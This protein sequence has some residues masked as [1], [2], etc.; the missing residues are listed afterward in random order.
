M[1]LLS[2]RDVPPRSLRVLD[3]AYKQSHTFAVLLSL[4]G[5]ILKAL[6]ASATWVV[7][8]NPV[9]FSANKQRV[10]IEGNEREKESGAEGGGMFMK[11]PNINKPTTTAVHT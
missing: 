11:G 8:P 7:P 10:Y 5:F 4:T 1:L 9:T 6:S 2:G 3:R